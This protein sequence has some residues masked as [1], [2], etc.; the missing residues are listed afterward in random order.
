MA[1]KD[2]QKLWISMLQT[3]IVSQRKLSIV[4]HLLPPQFIQKEQAMLPDCHQLFSYVSDLWE[5]LSILTL[6][7]PYDASSPPY[8]EFKWN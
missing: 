1:G 6:L 8:I 3:Q 2:P 4:I 5:S 7:E